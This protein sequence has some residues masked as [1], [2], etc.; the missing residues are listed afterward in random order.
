MYLFLND[1][2]Q[3]DALS[4]FLF[5]FFALDYVIKKVQEN[6]VGLKSNGAHSLPFCADDVNLF[7][8]NIDTIKKNTEFVIDSNREVGLEV[9]AE[10][11]KY[12]LLS[13]QQNAGQSHDIMIANRS[14]GNVAQFKCLGMTVTNQNWIQEEINRRLQYLL[15]FSTETFVFSSAVQKH[16]IYKII[17]LPLVLYRYETCSLILMEEHRLRVLRISGLKRKLHNLELRNLYSSPSIIRMIKSRR[18]RLVGHVARIREKRNAYRILVGM[19]EGK[20][21]LGRPR[22]KWMD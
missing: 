18:M 5:Q 15:P 20:R 21:P 1:K 19:S 16:R 22:R 10:K 6:Q 8:D 3:G 12:M 4:P 14:F 9:N 11:T 2:K 17:I 7:G 13:H